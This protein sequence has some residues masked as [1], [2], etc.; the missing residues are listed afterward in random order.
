MEAKKI[1][2]QH[3]SVYFL[4]QD[5]KKQVKDIDAQIYGCSSGKITGM[6]RGGKPVTREDMA[7]EKA[8]IQKRIERLEIVKAQKKE[9]V[10]AYIDTVF[11]PRH[12]KILTLYCIK[13]LPIW[14]IAELEG[15]SQRHTFRLYEQA[16]D[17][18][19]ITLDL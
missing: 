4:I 2:N 18:V 17:M 9:I 13:V 16:L 14:K 1:L 12:N 6:P 8:D 11:S 10:Q 3:R 7:N 19:D 15:Y 5:L